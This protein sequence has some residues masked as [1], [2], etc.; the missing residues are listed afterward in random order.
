[1]VVSK[2]FLEA[3]LKA[4]KKKKKRSSEGESEDSD[5]EA[6]E[7]AEVEGPPLDGTYKHWYWPI[8]G[9]QKRV[10]NLS[11]FYKSK[12]SGES[13]ENSAENMGSRKIALF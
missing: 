13:P 6:T 2:H 9:T 4:E 10:T 3:K 12:A 5:N 8:D 7:T 11:H 1:M